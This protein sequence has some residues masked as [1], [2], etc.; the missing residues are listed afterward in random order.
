LSEAGLRH[1]ELRVLRGG[2]IEIIQWIAP[3][4]QRVARGGGAVAE[5]S[6]EALGLEWLSIERVGG[7][8]PVTQNQS[9]DADEIGPAVSHQ[10][11]RDVG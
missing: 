3:A 2:L 1:F 6:T 8:L 5:G 11:L 10:R 9:A 4:G 7:E